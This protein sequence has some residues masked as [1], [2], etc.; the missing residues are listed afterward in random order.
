MSGAMTRIQ[1]P[2]GMARSLLFRHPEA[3]IP[4]GARLV[5]EVDECAVASAQGRVLGT[6]GPGNHV[7]SPD[8]HRFLEG[9]VDIVSGGDEL[10]CELY[11]IATGVFSGV[12]IHGSLGKLA[13]DDGD[14]LPLWFSTS[15]TV[16]AQDPELL[17]PALD[18]RRDDPMEA[19]KFIAARSLRASV[20]RLVKRGAVVP[21]TIA[22]EAAKVKKAAQ[23]DGLG[24]ATIGVELLAIDSLELLR[25]ARMQVPAAPAAPGSAPG[26]A[27]AGFGAHA[28]GSGAQPA[29][30]FGLPPTPGAAGGQGAPGF[31]VGTP[32][33]GFGTPPGS[34]LGGAPGFGGASAGQ[35]GGASPGLGAGAMMGGAA[36]A[37]LPGPSAGGN[38]LGWAIPG[39]PHVD[40]GTGIACY[41]DCYGVFTGAPVPPE[42]V[43]WVIDTIGEGLFGIA[44][45]FSG[46]V[47]EIPQHLAQL[48][49]LLNNQVQPRLAP[50]GLVGQVT[51]TRVELPPHD[52]GC[53][54]L[55]RRHGYR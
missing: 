18:S 24:L 26:P 36:M 49:M 7:M 3:R 37:G 14:P 15:L 19:V 50:T 23:E 35:P 43:Q 20:D 30:G 47:L 11:L 8:Q 53:A 55:L 16:R 4:V 54:D 34:G 31:G 45:S 44:S 12:E 39:V 28:G 17:V 9:A 38:E 32:P 6:W 21:A 2:P 25:E 52:P 42:R 40:Q 5:V 22:R 46:N 51:V 13:N 10:A 29:A 33:G 1:R 41:V 27:G 48:S